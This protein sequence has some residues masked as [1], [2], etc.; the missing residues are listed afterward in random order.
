MP[1]IHKR[2]ELGTYAGSDAMLRLLRNQGFQ[3]GDWPEDM[4]SQPGFAWSPRPVYV[5]LIEV[6]AAE[7][8]FK[9]KVRYG[10]V[11]KTLLQEGYELCPHEVG[12]QW[13]RQYPDQPA[14]N[15]VMLA[16]NPIVDSVGYQSIF[17]LGRGSGGLWLGASR[18][19]PNVLLK[20]ESRFAACCSMP[21][22]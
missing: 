13:R 10:D 18:G 2:V 19:H 21:A 3:V 12:P 4:I 9:N 16:M 20:P 14:N 11:T 7:L 5:D 15:W 1:I 8:G 6:S 22:A 17:F